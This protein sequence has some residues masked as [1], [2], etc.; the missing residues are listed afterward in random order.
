[1]I[2]RASKLWPKSE[3]IQ[4]AVDVINEHEGIDFNTM[5]GAFIDAPAEG[6]VADDKTFKNIR[7]LLAFNKRTEDQLLK[8]INGKFKT[9]LKNIE[10][11]EPVHIEEAYRALGERK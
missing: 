10:E 3:R 11:M 2:K 6:L 1:V 8:Y 5:R 9:E 4:T 7:D